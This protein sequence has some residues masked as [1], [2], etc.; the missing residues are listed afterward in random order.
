ML[1]E[2]TFCRLR[3]EREKEG[4]GG[5]LGN[6]DVDDHPLVVLVDHCMSKKVISIHYMPFMPS[7]YIPLAN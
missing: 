5:R 3:L 1:S 4:D 7:G 6:L 2:D